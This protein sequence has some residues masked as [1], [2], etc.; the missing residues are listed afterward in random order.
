MRKSLFTAIA[1]LLSIIVVPAM[2]AQKADKKKVIEDLKAAFT[3]ETTASAKYA[4]YAEKARME[5]FGKIALLFEAASKAENIHAGNHQAAL[6]QL[7]VSAPAVEPK[8]E[9]RST[10]E[11][12]QDAIKGET[13]E[14]ETM[15]PN[16]IR[17]G[18]EARV[19]IALITFN[20]A[21]KTEMKHKALYEEALKALE[22]DNIDNLASKYQVC[23]TCGNTYQ[24]EGPARCG[25]C[26]TSNDRFITIE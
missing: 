1:I 25:I 17:D 13:Y 3:G 2:S 6:E 7:G 10:K 4:A 8:Y 24:N 20:Y 21:H 22:A 14:S 19:T 18:N 12:L 16:F 11:N 5:G 15:Y 23:T 26:M 9:V